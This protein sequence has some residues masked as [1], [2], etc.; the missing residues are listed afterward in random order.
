MPERWD[1]R[2]PQLLVVVSPASMRG[3]CSE[4]IWCRCMVSFPFRYLRPWRQVAFCGA[5]METEWYLEWAG[6]AVALEF[7]SRIMTSVGSNYS[8]RVGC[9][10]LFVR[11]ED[12]FLSITYLWQGTKS[13]CQ[14]LGIPL[15]L[16]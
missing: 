5:F 7:H 14:A 8:V 6:R 10:W 12:L 1:R 4:C 15:G 11:I 16:H 13:L 2:H 3:P 9:V